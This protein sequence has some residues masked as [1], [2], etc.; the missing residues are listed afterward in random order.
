MLGNVDEWVAD[1]HDKEY[2]AVSPVVNPTRPSS[3]NASVI[4]WRVLRS[5][6]SYFK[7]EDISVA[8]RQ[9]APGFDNL[10]GVG[11]RC[12]STAGVIPVYSTATP[13]IDGAAELELS[14]IHMMNKTDGR[15]I[16][17]DDVLLTR[18]GGQT[19]REASPPEN[20]AAYA[21]EFGTRLYF[22]AVDA[23]HAW[24]I[25]APKPFQALHF[26]IPY[27]AQIWY[28]TDSGQTWAAS[29]PLMHDL[30]M[31]CRAAIHMNDTQNGWISI[32]G[33]YT[34]AG[35]RTEFRLFQTMDGG[36]NWE[37]INTVT[38]DGQ[39]SFVDPWYGWAVAGS[40]A[41]EIALVYTT[42]GGE[43]WKILNPVETE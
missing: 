9:G 26:C 3:E 13:A 11:F 1:L 33:W 42:N 41:G 38:W 28:T 7:Y 8:Y 36:K 31:D 12:A 10:H 17:G 15:G 4:D 37:R 20:T 22:E 43:A 35:P 21:K 19:W 30:A 16:N 25:Y 23:D 6:S 18:D 29:Q 32:N 39:F 40:E 14:A 5:G 24:L 27:N 2:Y 34:G